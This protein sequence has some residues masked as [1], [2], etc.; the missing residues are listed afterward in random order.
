M[1]LTDSRS[2]NT[3]N[4]ALQ[5]GHARSRYHFEEVGANTLR[6]KGEG[7]TT[8]TVGLAC[9]GRGFGVEYAGARPFD[10]EETEVKYFGLFDY[11]RL[12]QEVAHGLMGEWYRRRDGYVPH[13]LPPWLGQRTGTA[14]GKRLHSWYTRQLSL[15]SPE[16]LRV[17]RTVFAATLTTP[18]VLLDPGFY[19][20][21]RAEAPYLLE[22]L[23]NHRA[24]GI[25]LVNLH[26]FPK[27][28][29]IEHRRAYEEMQRSAEYAALAEMVEQCYG[30]SVDVLLGMPAPRR[31]A[32]TAI[33]RMQNW[34]ALFSPTG[35]SYRSLDRTLTNLPGGVPHSLVP[36]LHRVRLE[37]PITKRLGLL[38][39]CA[40]GRALADRDFLEPDIHERI[41]LSA[42]PDR[43]VRAVRLIS[44]HTRNELSPRRARDVIFAANFMLDCREA[45]QGNIVGLAE[46]AIAWHRNEMRSQAERIVAQL[47]GACETA[48]LPVPLP[49]KLAEAVTFLE[50]VQDVCEE[51]ARMNN[52]VA[53]YA[54][55]AVNGSC[56]LFHISRGGEEATV[57]VG[58][59]GHVRQAAGPSNRANAA[60]RWGRREL[61]RWGHGFPSEALEAFRATPGDDLT[62]LARDLDEVGDF[63]LRSAQAR[64]A[65]RGGHARRSANP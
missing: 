30:A 19:T 14:I 33:E 18:E 41:F 43:I 53:F 63:R 20:A 64:R 60:A 48:K 56:Y 15:A 27:P 6:I 47:G 57:E 51:G 16:V 36:Y 31:E 42:A 49:A 24:A 58:R 22:D 55:E 35:E 9:A 10:P 3:P 4:G 25:A 46:K 62:A 45:H 40:Y 21:S 26:K 50:T 32:A 12:S 23:A 29:E 44:A 7:R 34:R 2:A 37:A 13:W 1:E 65:R 38:M 8:V 39:A 52:C 61:E 5:G 59:D 17:Q 11:R 54:R 28:A